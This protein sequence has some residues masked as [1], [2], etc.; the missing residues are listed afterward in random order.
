[1]LKAVIFDLDG[2]IGNTLPLC[3]A[4]FRQAV[5]PLAGKKLSDE[6]IVATFGPSEEGTIMQLI[7]GHYRQGVD[8]YI[9]HYER[10]HDMCPEPFAGIRTIIER[11]KARGVTVA[12]VTGK[13][14][15]S[16]RITLERYGM[17]GLFDAVET[18]SPQ[19]QRK[20][21][22]IRAV[23]DRFG[24]QPG[25]AVYVG[26]A[27]SDVTASR[28]AG[29]QVIAAAWAATADVETLAA[30]APDRLFTSVDE[31]ESYL[32]DNPDTV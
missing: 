8:D 4:A 25:Q 13:G 10:L 22:G 29:V 3:V 12:M 6:E 18:G 31:L 19:G 14:A 2:T 20:A 32:L 21:E 30:M 16:C 24:L 5:E 1:M 26:D 17:D 27:P 11:L 15:R 9:S 7:P 23:L 28:A